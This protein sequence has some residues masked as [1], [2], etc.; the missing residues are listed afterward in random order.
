MPNI[1]RAN[2]AINYE[3]MGPATGRPLVLIAGLGEQI[4][5]VE[6]PD[7]HCSVF[8]QRG[9]R[10][11]RIDNRDCG[12]SLPDNELPPRDVMKTLMDMQVS[13][14]GSPDYTLRDM[15]DDVAAVLDD[16]GIAKANIVGA[17]LG[18]F[19]ARWFAIRH[20]RRIE[21]LSV[22]MSGNGAGPGDD[23]EQPDPGG[24]PFLVSL[25]ARR[26]AGEAIKHGVASWKYL[27]GSQYRF[28]EKWVS[29]RVTFAFNRSYRPEGIGRTLVAAFNSPGIWSLQR[30]I[31]CP[32]LIMHGTEDPIISFN[33]ARQTHSRIAESTLWA[34]TGMGHTMHDELWPE[35]ADRLSALATRAAM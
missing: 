1:R 25:G 17:S 11:I 21:S 35:M 5:S 10:V 12:L 22:V 32:T 13:V 28:D 31:A 14:E 29:D 19:I 33:Q 3:L 18:G 7:E 8:V 27:W 6:F 23:G 16:L 26:P 20:P 2:F 4:G 24:L 15:A 30:T 34:V 9:F